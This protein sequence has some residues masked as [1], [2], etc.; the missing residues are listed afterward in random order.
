M[1]TITECQRVHSITLSFLS[2]WYLCM[3]SQQA[4]AQESDV[5][6]EVSM[7]MEHL[8]FVVEESW[9]WALSCTSPC[10]RDVA[11]HRSYVDIEPLQESQTHA[12]GKLYVVQK[13]I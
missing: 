6:R 3:K 9:R 12:H 10:S 4:D 7:N 5:E 8:D 11:V 2:A 1:H 13:A